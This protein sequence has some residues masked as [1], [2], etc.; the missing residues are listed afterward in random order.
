MAN[1]TT[2]NPGSGGDSIATDDVSGVKYQRVKLVDGTEDSTAGIPGDATNGLFVN[3]KALP[4]LVAGSAVIGKVDVN[5][6]PA[7]AVDGGALPAVVQV[8]GGFDG[9]NVQAVKTDSA[10]VLQVQPAAVVPV[11][12]NGGSLTVDGTVGV[13]SAGDVAGTLTNG[14]KT[15]TTPG[16]PVAL[17]SSAACAWVAVTALASNADVVSVG[18][19][20][21]LATAGSETGVVLAPGAS[22]TIPTTN[23][24]NVFVDALVAGNGVSFLAGA[25]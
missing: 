8:V 22:V 1:N 23:V 7:Q 2:L 19:S 16:T 15:V 6:D 17:A 13:A 4:A 10:G 12:D 21:V 18:G 25:L 24:S 9:V 14:R 5:T 3:V 20:G 11:S